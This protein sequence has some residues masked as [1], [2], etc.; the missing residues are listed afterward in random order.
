[1]DDQT[2]I[3]SPEIVQEVVDVAIDAAEKCGFTINKNKSCVLCKSPI[4]LQEDSPALQIPIANPDEP[5]KILGINATDSFEEFNNNI[6]ERIDR[7]FDSLDKIEVHPEI[8]HMILHFCGRP[9][10]QYF[11]ETT[12]P[13]FG[14][15]VV[16]HFQQRLKSSFGKIIGVDEVELIRDEMLFNSHGGNLPDYVSHHEELYTKTTTFVELRSANRPSMEPFTVELISSSKDNF[17]SLECAHDRHWTH[18]ISPSKVTQLTSVQYRNALAFRMKMI[19]SLFSKECGDDY[20][21]CHC[22]QLMCI[23]NLTKEQE[24]EMNTSG[25]QVPLLQHIIKCPKMHNM[26]DSNRHQLVKDAMRTIAS[27]Y[28]ITVYNEPHFYDYLDGLHNRPDLTFCISSQRAFI[29]TDITIVQPHENPS[30]EFI[31]RAALEAANKK[32]EKHAAAVHLRNHQFIPF[33]L[34]TTGHFDRAA[35]ELIRV[36]KDSL[37]FAL[38]LNF[39]R[40]MYGCVSSALAEYRA[41]ILT[42]T[43]TRAKTRK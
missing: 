38:R 29:T 9:R 10:I 15:D 23:K 11:C 14:A 4:P 42:A 1:M 25:Q 18:F 35:R 27:S 37:P 32:I 40:D 13:K 21:Q 30:V 31:G 28:G 20:L 24:T 7:F 2:I 39:M 16:N 33:A 5:M 6:T 8:K 17:T 12:P 41:E 36:L 43:L 3:C 26:Y 22:G 34:E 19:P